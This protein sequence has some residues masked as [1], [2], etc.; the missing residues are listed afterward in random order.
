MQLAVIVLQCVALGLSNE[1]QFSRSTAKLTV[2]GTT[3]FV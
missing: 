3:T 2:S 1:A